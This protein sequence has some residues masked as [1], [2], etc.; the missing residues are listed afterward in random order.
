MKTY[1]YQDG[2]R[3]IQLVEKS[4]LDQL[5]ERLAEARE[6]HLA[7]SARDVQMIQRQ[8]VEL[9]KREVLA[10]ML[11]TALDSSAKLYENPEPPSMHELSMRAYDMR[12][13][14]RQAL[15]AYESTN[16]EPVVRLNAAAPDL[17]EALEAI[18]G[19]D[20]FE[21][22]GSAAFWLQD[23]VKAAIAKAKGEQL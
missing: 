6:S 12:C 10:K 11:A 16:S 14:A 9:S 13:I 15:S 7:A 8:S 1:P 2:D 4:E 3:L 17:L 18:M 20:L 5:L 23:K 19:S 22:N 21:W